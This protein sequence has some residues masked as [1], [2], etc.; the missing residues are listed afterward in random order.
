MASCLWSRT[1][2]D[3]GVSTA[4]L[5]RQT[6]RGTEICFF[7]CSSQSLCY[8]VSEA[9]CL[10]SQQCSVL[11]SVPASSRLCSDSDPQAFFSS[12]HLAFY[13]IQARLQLETYYLAISADTFFSQY[14]ISCGGFRYCE[15]ASFVVGLKYCWPAT[16]G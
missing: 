12:C 5:P 2:C 7:F 15:L 14:K 9:P 13:I 8:S 3:P 11:Q 6:L 1:V 16:L 10:N 4:V